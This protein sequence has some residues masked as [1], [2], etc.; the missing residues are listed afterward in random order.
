MARKYSGLVYT[1]KE[2]GRVHYLSEYGVA[3]ACFRKD[4]N[5]F[6][7]YYLSSYI[8]NEL[9][10]GNWIK[11]EEKYCPEFKNK[12]YNNRSSCGTCCCIF[13][14]YFFY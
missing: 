8:H 14:L 10:K 12:K 9:K 3:Y 6:V 7:C 2:T 5:A 13:N 4:N 1:E 11:S